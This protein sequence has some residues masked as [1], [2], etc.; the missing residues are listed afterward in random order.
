[1]GDF[2]RYFIEGMAKQAIELTCVAILKILKYVPG[3]Q[4]LDEVVSLKPRYLTLVPDGLKIQ[5]MCNETVHIDPWLLYDV[6]DYLKTQEMYK[7]VVEKNPKVLKYVSDQFKTQ[8]MCGESVRYDSSSLQYVPDYFVTQQQVKIWYNYNG[9]CKVN[10][11]IKWYNGYQ[12]L[13][14]QK[15]Q[16]KEELIAIACYPSKWWDWCMSEEGKKETE[17]LWA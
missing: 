3:V 4:G 17:K 13:K 16:I 8:K 15:A 12:K 9:C 5:E 6:P 14:T 11:L 1:M 2:I 10:E 7:R